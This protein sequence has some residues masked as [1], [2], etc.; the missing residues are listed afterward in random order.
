MKRFG[1]AEKSFRKVAS[2][3]EKLVREHPTIDRQ[4]ALAAARVLWGDALG[5]L[6]HWAE[7]A[8]QYSKA[9]TIGEASWPI[10]VR[11]ARTHLAAGDDDAYSAVCRQLAP[12]LG[13]EAASDEL[14]A[15]ALTLVVGENAL[16]DPSQLVAIA[17]RAAE[18]E[19]GPI[20]QL[21]VGAAEFRAG[22]DQQAIATLEQALARL[23]Q[24][25]V[26][27]GNNR[28]RTLSI[29]I[30]GQSLLA[31]AGAQQGDQTAGQLEAMPD[32]E[33]RSA[34]V[35]PSDRE[36]LP[37]W[38]VGFSREILRRRARQ[39]NR[40]TRRVTSPSTEQTAEMS[41]RCDSRGSAISLAKPR[42]PIERRVRGGRF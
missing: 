39:G 32:P 11:S 31:R 4:R 10:L 29:R 35:A 12:R 41:T 37:P 2:I 23:D 1:D 36:G 20:A 22:R 19:P 16:A 33:S 18:A 3:R 17:N 13:N 25:M 15:V 9:A 40:G 42:A 8:G 5:M 38:I 7:A 14:M 6:G 21:L 26:T 27:A 34:A 24:E 30:V 28:N